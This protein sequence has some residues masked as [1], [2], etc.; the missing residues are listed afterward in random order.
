MGNYALKHH[1][2]I[3]HVLLIS[4]IGVKP[5]FKDEPE[6][7]PYKRFEGKVNGPPRGTAFL[8]R[9]ICNKKISPLSPGRYVWKNISLPLIKKYVIRRQ[10]CDNDE[11]KEWI[12]RYLYQ[13]FMRP[14][15]TEYLLMVNFNFSL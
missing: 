1:M 10:K 12:T 5:I 4:P 7:H 6:L 9:Y 2:H 14:G 13:I 8:G 11:M 3:K 15:T